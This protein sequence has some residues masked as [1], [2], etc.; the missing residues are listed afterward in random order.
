MR[1]LWVGRYAVLSIVAGALLASC[2]GSQ[3]SPMAQTIPQARTAGSHS[4]TPACSGSR[5]GQA[6]CDVLVENVPAIKAGAH[7]AYGGWGAPD[8]E[9]AYNLPITKGSGNNVFIVDAYD[10]PDV[11]SDFNTYRST[12][13]LPASTLNKYNQSGQKSNYPQ[14][15]PGWG[16]EI[17]LDVDM[18]SAA[19]PLCTINLVEA[20]S[21]QW[22]DL[23]AAEQE[24]VKLG[25]TIISN[26]YSGTGASE[27][28]YDTKGVEYLASAGD[29]GI[30]LIDPATFDSVVAVGGTELSKTSGSRG[31][32]ETTWYG[33]G[34]GC[35]STGEPKP[36]WQKKNK[37]AKSCSYRMG[38]DV[39]AVAVDA[40]EYDTDSEGGWIQVDGTSI[41]SPLNAGVFGLAGNSTSQDGGKTF[42]NKKHDKSLYEVGNQRFSDQGGFGSPDGTGA[43]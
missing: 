32:S 8:L 5:I 38:A 7:P 27:S 2:S 33:S 40:A 42:W 28:D 19:C 26:S 25:A 23:E 31:Y 1:S 34:G 15:S 43:F 9:K 41:S 21:S 6:Q 35:S 29:S 30:S 4:A 11:S 18:A 13:G 36:K 3:S 37:Y 14:N 16:V 39:S 20:N 22:T 17:D 10:N 24:A 12:M